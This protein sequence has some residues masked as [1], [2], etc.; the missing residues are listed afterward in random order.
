MGKL[1][2]GISKVEITPSKKIYLT[3]YILRDRPCEGI[4]DHLYAKAV[5]LK[6]LDTEDAAAVISA[7]L[8]GFS[9]ESVDRI[10]NE[11]SQKTGIEPRNMIIACTHTHSAPA[12]VN[13]RKVGVVDVNYLKNVE[14]KIVYIILDAYKNL[15]E[16]KISAGRSVVRGI[17]YNREKRGGPVDEELGVIRIDNKKDEILALL[18]NYACHPVVLGPRN[19]LVSADYPGAVARLIEEAT[20]SC[21]IYTTGADGDIDPVTNLKKWGEGTFRDVEEIGKIIG[22]QALKVSEKLKGSSNVKLKSLSKTLRLP[23]KSP[24]TLKEAEKN[25]E[26]NRKELVKLKS[27]GV[28]NTK[29]RIAEAIFEWS[30]EV[31]KRIKDGTF[32]SEMP[33]EI[34]MIGIND[35]LL[36]GVPGELFVEIGL[37]VKKASPFTYTYIIGYG[38]GELG[39]FPTAEAIKR[40]GYASRTAPKYFGVTFL[41]PEAGDILENEI[42]NMTHQIY[43]M[44]EC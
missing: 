42:I 1:A 5:V 17:G 13:L 6:D 31:L 3:G 4:H 33:V 21:C 34:T 32:P 22:L 25:L 8:L 37:K 39:Y 40:G 16:A 26:R 11:A 30:K 15:Q 20:G 14:E 24:P 28:E 27:A 18:L 44:M 19:L 7:D 43:E 29:I 36:V 35:V 10:R 12:T 2:A 23:V 41:K 9:K 38:N